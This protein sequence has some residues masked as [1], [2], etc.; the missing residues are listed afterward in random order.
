MQQT[1]RAPLRRFQRHLRRGFLPS[2]NWPGALPPRSPSG[3]PFHLKPLRN[4]D[5]THL[6]VI[7]TVTAIQ[8][9]FEK[10]FGQE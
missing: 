5:R 8:A 10:R 9:L 4:L 6:V 7:T 2:P 3:L 1:F